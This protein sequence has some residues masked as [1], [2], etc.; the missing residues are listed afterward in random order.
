MPHDRLL[1]FD[2]DSTLCSIEG[3][4][5]LAATRPESV[6]QQIAQA[7]TDAMEGRLRVEDVFARRLELLQPTRAELDQVAQRYLDTLLPSAEP[8]VRELR[9][10][11]WEML[12]LSGGLRPAI[13]PSAARLGIERVEAVD[14]SFDAEGHYLDFDRAFPTTRSGGKPDFVRELRVS[15]PQWQ[16]VVMVGD[17]VSDL[18]TL[19]VVDQFIG[20]GGVAVREKVKAGASFFILDLAELPALLTQPVRS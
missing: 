20:F 8:C 16:T 4:D 14:I 17:G 10:A 15:E 3:V 7:T 11:G 9:T 19:P 6:R 5:E 13:L 12:I 2:F 18:E 1:I